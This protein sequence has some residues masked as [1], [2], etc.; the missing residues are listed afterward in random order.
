MVEEWKTVIYNGEVF[1]EY[2]VSN[3]GHVRSLKCGKVRE[4]KLRKNKD[5]YL[6]VQLY[7]G[8]EKYCYVHRLV[9]CTFIPNDDETKTDVNHISEVKTENFVE[10][11]EWCTSDYNVNY[12]TRN[13]RD[14]KSHCKKVIGKSLTENKVVVLQSAKQGE[15]FGFK[16][17]GITACCRGERKS[18]HGYT[19]QYID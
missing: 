4:M 6:Y 1:E 8:K 12:G 11:L 17:Q 15:K 9:A 19:W 2:E 13:E 18:H 10:N 3:L 14:A 5:G 7:Q 16:Q